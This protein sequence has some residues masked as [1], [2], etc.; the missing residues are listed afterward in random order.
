MSENLL[1]HAQFELP[2]IPAGLPAKHPFRDKDTHD[3]LLEYLKDRINFD[4]ANRDGRVVRYAQI[5]RDVA[6]WMKLDDE[7]AKR[8]AKHEKDGSPQATAVSLPLSFV[9]LDDM[10]T[11]YAQTFAP[12]RGMF[13]HTAG[14]DESAEATQLVALMNMHAIHGGYYRQLLRAI[15]AI[16]K[17][18]QGGVINSWDTEYGP[19]LVADETGGLQVESEKV[20]VGNRIKAADMYNFF[21]DPSVELADLYKEG[22]WF[23]FTEM[24]SHYWLKSKCL[25]GRFFNCQDLLD[26]RRSEALTAVFYKDPP[27]ESRLE[28]DETSGRKT[29]SWYSLLSGKDSYAT[30][31]AYE[32]TTVYVRINPNDFNLIPASQKR[33]RNRY[34]VWRFTMVGDQRIIEAE[35]MNNIHGHLPAYFGTLNDDQMRDSAK[36]V[37]EILNPL[38]QFASFLLNA[39][40]QANR[41]NIYGTTYYDPTAIDMSKI[42]QGE[43]AAR[44]PM[45]P[46]AYGRDIRQFIYH[47]NNVLDTKQTLDDLQGMMGIINQ[48]FPTQSMPSQ[49]AS[50]DR[51]VDSQVAAVQQGTNR[52]Q[53]KGARLIDDTMLRPMRFGM[54]Y[55]IVQYQEDGQDV[56]DFFTGTNYK[57]DLSGL[58]GM[59]LSYIIG[60]GLK[61][62]DRQ[63]IQTQLRD[64]IFALI[65]AP[66]TQQGIDLLGLLDHWTTMMDLDMNL[67]QFE[68]AP[69][70]SGAE[71]ATQA[72][73]DAGGNPVVPATDPSRI[74]GGPI[75]GG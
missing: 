36:S 39:H 70:Q 30:N 24:K 38:Q 73:V 20:F 27:V 43:V 5:D 58:R 40:V 47:D 62:L 13:Y 31:G 59:N 55:N 61:A 56:A 10:M 9:H 8:Q 3:K 68:M 53:H 63:A 50:I 26:E 49:I 67:K 4:K 69:A 45:K 51:A 17:Y 71:G 1:T 75:Y 74:A 22:E 7:D 66:Q 60:Q 37:A 6:A 2:Q 52:R 57:V 16:L 21:Y 72:G 65:Q 42:P 64:I 41:K 14:K 32:L 44:V 19:K 18:N 12:N 25:E 35:Y 11:Y 29:F 34:E 23:A 15:W 46:A 28:S 33:A 54:Y 48:F